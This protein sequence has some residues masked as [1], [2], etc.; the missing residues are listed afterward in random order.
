MF[1]FQTDRALRCE[2][3]TL[4][5]QSH[6]TPNNREITVQRRCYAH[7]WCFRILRVNQKSIKWTWVELFEMNKKIEQGSNFVVGNGSRLFFDAQEAKKVSK[8]TV[9]R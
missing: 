8:H 3:T 5:L 9:V 1:K 2:D 7:V 6:H 4:C